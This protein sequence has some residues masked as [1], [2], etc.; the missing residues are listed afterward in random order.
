MVLSLTPDFISSLSGRF[1]D[2]CGRVPTTGGALSGQ[3]KQISRVPLSVRAFGIFSKR[4]SDHLLAVCLNTWCL[5][6]PRSYSPAPEVC[7]TRTA[8]DSFVRCKQLIMSFVFANHFHDDLVVSG[9]TY[10]HR[11]RS[12]CRETF[13]K[14]E[15]AQSCCSTRH[16]LLLPP[17][18]PHVRP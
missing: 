18:A 10:S 14:R 6:D 5:K 1:L 3:N 11:R 4:F 12:I 16:H 15:A 7:R 8:K 17:Q 2:S 13:Q 9:G